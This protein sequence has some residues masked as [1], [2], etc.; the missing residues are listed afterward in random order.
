LCTYSYF[1]G[2]NEDK[3]GSPNPYH[4]AQ[5]GPPSVLFHNDGHGHFVDVTE[6]VGLDNNDRFHFAGA[7]ADYDE[8]GWPD[9]LVAND[10]GR[11]NLYHN[12]GLKNGK[13]HFK[14]VAG[15]AGVEDYGAGMSATWLDYDNDGHLD[16]Y[17]GNMWTANGRRIVNE[18]GFMP[19][20]S[21][22]IHDIY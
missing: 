2:T 14:D 17:T 6:E 7:W 20:V 8:D 4:N 19:E 16:I 11:K 18:P 15:P 22:E 1:I 3:G 5:N 9:L 21:P 12:E 13:I 10:F